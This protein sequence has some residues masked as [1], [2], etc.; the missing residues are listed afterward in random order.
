MSCEDYRERIALF[1]GGELP[2]PDPQAV[3]RHIAECEEC[4]A[5]AAELDEVRGLLGG[6]AAEAA[7]EEALREVRFHVNERIAR[8]ARRWQWAAVAAAAM[9]AVTAGVEWMDRPQM[10]PPP[11][12]RI[13]PPE[14][15]T[16][17]EMT[18]APSVP[19]VVEESPSPL[20]VAAVTAPLKNVAPAA[21]VE[22]PATATARAREP[23][24]VK[25]LTD[26][27]NIVIYWVAEE[28]GG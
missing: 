17:A 22:E 27:P 8:P 2:E 9:I 12:V 21:R 14:A 6:L 28:S 3:E 10:P 7:P 16:I 23:L 20:P 18:P 5:L 15:P 13:E 19:V 24:V 4:R 1:I 25:F 11:Q 26:D